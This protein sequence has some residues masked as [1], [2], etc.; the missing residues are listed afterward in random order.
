MRGKNL[1]EFTPHLDL[2]GYVVII[3]TD[4]IK[5]T[6]QKG[7]QKKYFHFSGYPGGMKAKGLNESLVQD[8][9]K[10]LW[11]AVRNMLPANKLRIE[12]MKRL[13][14]FKGAEHTFAGKLNK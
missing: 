4:K 3:N 2:G 9:G 7:A 12:M 1:V 6:G 5:I 11:S 8:S 14:T 10:V 13:K